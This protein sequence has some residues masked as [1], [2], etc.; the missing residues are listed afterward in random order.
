MASTVRFFSYLEVEIEGEKHRIGSLSEAR[1]LSVTG[2]ALDLRK[3]IGTSTTWDVWESGADEPMTDFDV[4]CIESELSGVIV[5]LTADKGGEVGTRVF[6][7]ELTADC[8]FFLFSDGSW[9]N[10][11][12]DFA[13]GTLDVIDRIRIRNVNASSTASVRVLMLT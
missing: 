1:T 13:A 6:T 9:A 3:I 12:A 10:Y 11:T 2:A 8:P 4:L 5:E 7:V